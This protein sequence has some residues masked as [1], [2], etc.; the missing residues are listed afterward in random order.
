MKRMGKEANQSHTSNSLPL[1]LTISPHNE[2][3]GADFLS[4]GAIYILERFLPST[5]C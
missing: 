4:T 3:V 2:N 1:S 5:S